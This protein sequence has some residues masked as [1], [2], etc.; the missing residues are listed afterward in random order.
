[1]CDLEQQDCPIVYASDSFT[2]LTGYSQA[3]I[4]G[5]NCRFL[6]APGGKVRRSSTRKHVD[7]AV[8]K[9]MRH[10]LERNEEVALEVTNFKK[11]GEK[12]VNLLAMIP[13]FWD[14]ATPRYC[15]GFQA[16]KTW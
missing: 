5:Q 8:V 11:N 3:E 2:Q 9:Q 13:V 4:L 1:M 10:A 7:K 12:F 15:V 14:S 6:Q 16:E